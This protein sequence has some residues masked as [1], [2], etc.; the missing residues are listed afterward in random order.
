MRVAAVAGVAR[1]GA[2]VKARARAK[3]GAESSLTGASFVWRDKALD[4]LRRGRNVE[5]FARPPPTLPPPA[6]APR[7]TK[8]GL[9]SVWIPP[10][11][12]K[13]VRSL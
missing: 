13:L 5:E 7:Q 6:F 11:S 1:Q 3:S 8:D 12:S 2:L 10:L 4:F 9:P